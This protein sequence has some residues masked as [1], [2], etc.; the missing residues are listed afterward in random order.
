MTLRNLSASITGSS[1]ITN[2]QI[3]ESYSQLSASAVVE[4]STTSLNLGDAIT[5]ALGYD[6]ST[7]DLFKGFI[8]KRERIRPDNIYRLHCNDLL[9]KAVDYFMA[10]DDPENP[11]KRNNISSLN[12]VKDLL[13]QAGISNV[14]NTEPIPIFTWG[15]SEE[16]VKFNLQS[17]A[18]AIQF[19]AQTTGNTIYYD[20]VNDI[21]EFR[22]RKPYVDVGDVAV[23]P[24]F[25]TGS[26]GNILSISYESSSDR[27]RNR[28][29]IYGKG[30]IHATR[31]AASPYVVVD[32]TLVLAHELIDT[33]VLADGSAEVNLTILNRLGETYNI[34]L[35]GSASTRAREV[36]NLTESF[37]G[38]SNRPVFLYSV[39]HSYSESGWV[40]QV[41][42]I[43]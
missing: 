13:A 8:K 39:S 35:E 10:S 4:C 6:G 14:T 43:P 36:H 23:A 32:Q 9:G 12:L 26:A 16:G 25:T 17:V 28:I 31:S 20:S 24:A 5:I 11:F 30:N 21:V 40:T 38:A 18:D 34:D 41:V 3:T 42:A 22:G 33:Q 7:T 1:N 15:T 29:V 2:I 19:V 37:I 27:I